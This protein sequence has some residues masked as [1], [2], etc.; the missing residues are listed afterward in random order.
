M[1]ELDAIVER[2]RPSDAAPSGFVPPKPRT[3]SRFAAMPHCTSH[4][5]T[6][7]ARLSESC[8][9]F[10]SSVGR[11]LTWTVDA[12][13]QDLGMRA[14]RRADLAEHVVARRLRASAFVN[15]IDSSRSMR[16]G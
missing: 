15:W 5:R 1:I 9:S 13:A 4:S 7:C 3:S 14:Q 8:W 2:A 12:H 11:R 6:A 16:S 10:V